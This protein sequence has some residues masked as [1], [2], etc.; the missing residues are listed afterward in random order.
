M[1]RLSIAVLGIAG[2]LLVGG[3]VQAREY[4][5]FYNSQSKCLAEIDINAKEVA[6]VYDDEFGPAAEELPAE[7]KYSDYFVARYPDGS[8]VFILNA[9]FNCGRLGC[10][11]Q[12]YV[13]DADGDL[14]LKDSSFPVLCQQHEPDKLLCTK[15]GYKVKKTP[16]IKPKGPIHY[17]APR[18]EGAGVPLKTVR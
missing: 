14:M 6:K 2:G 10:N 18:P 8:Y 4:Y 17:P 1:L 5:L 13:R 7:V 9:P 11:T 16:K 3:N 12:V 15:G